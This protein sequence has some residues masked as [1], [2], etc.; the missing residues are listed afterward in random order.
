M[1]KFEN[2]KVSK[3]KYFEYVG[4]GYEYFE[5]N[6]IIYKKEYP[7]KSPNR[8]A[9]KRLMKALVKLVIYK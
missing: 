7:N 6:Q 8:E 4:T 3:E 5:E 1:E 9:F 2:Q